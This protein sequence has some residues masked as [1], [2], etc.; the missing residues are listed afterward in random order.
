[1]HKVVQ[2]VQQLIT[3]LVQLSLETWLDKEWDP[4]CDAVQP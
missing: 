1:M 2:H 3:Q 4:E